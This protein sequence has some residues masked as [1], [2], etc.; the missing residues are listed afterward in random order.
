MRR[1][2]IA[3]REAIRECKKYGDIRLML[4]G[5]VIRN[6]PIRSKTKGG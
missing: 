2:H 3:K 6:T 5:H 1:L 4:A